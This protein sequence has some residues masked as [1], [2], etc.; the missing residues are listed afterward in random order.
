LI[1]TFIDFARKSCYSLLFFA[2]DFFAFIRHKPSLLG[3]RL[4]SFVTTT[5]NGLVA[6]KK[7]FIINDVSTGEEGKVVG[8]SDSVFWTCRKKP[9]EI[10]TSDESFRLIF[11]EVFD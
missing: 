11:S 10:Q 7:L 5:N 8:N 4:Q 1:S 3:D 9:T 6:S 2:V